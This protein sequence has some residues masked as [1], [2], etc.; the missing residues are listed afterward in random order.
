MTRIRVSA[1]GKAVIAG[2]YAVLFGAPA[3]VTAINRRAEVR[4]VESADRYHHVS[5]PGLADG[6]WRF[7]CGPGGRVDWQDEVAGGLLDL[8]ECAWRH[9]AGGTPF[10]SPE[11]TSTPA[12]SRWVSRCSSR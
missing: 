11:S 8:F 10:A 2:E 7:H 9:C 1:P 4:I 3:L 12:I 5:V 6:C